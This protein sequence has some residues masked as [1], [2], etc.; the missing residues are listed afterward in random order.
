M[1]ES[2]ETSATITASDAFLHSAVGPASNDAQVSSAGSATAGT[3]GGGVIFP[4]T[5]Q[6]WPLGIPTV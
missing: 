3:A 2:I 4:A 5:G 6:Q 1:P